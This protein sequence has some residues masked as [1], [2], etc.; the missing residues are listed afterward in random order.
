MRKARDRVNLGEV[1]VGSLRT[2]R[3]ATG[4]LVLEVPGP[5]G[6]AKAD[7]LAVQLGEALRDQEGV[8]V[9]RLHKMADIRVRD[10]EDSISPEAV[11]A[12][13]AE[14]GECAQTLVK[15]GVIRTI[16]DDLGL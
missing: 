2:R 14:A 16:R 11:A 5:D 3:G 7:A 4:A 8:V 12:R 10:L 6:H 13:I 1:G 9:A 15:V